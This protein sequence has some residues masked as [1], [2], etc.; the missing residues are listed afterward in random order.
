MEKKHLCVRFP[1]VGLRDCL[2]CLLGGHDVGR[3]A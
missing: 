3:L 1:F 2:K